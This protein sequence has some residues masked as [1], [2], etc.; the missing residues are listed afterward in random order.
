MATTVI[1]GALHMHHVDHD[2]FGRTDV[3]YFRLRLIRVEFV[4]PN[5]LEVRRVHK[6]QFG[7]LVDAAT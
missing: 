1:E 3:E 6:Y 7:K 5:A 2:L 4:L